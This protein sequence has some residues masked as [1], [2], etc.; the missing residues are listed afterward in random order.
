MEITK[1][2]KQKQ[3]REKL[4]KYIASVPGLEKV[5]DAKMDESQEGMI[6]SVE[7]VMKAKLESARLQGVQIGW[8]TFAKQA[9]KHIKKMETVDEIKVYFQ[10][11]ADKMDE[12]LGIKKD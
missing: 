5:L 11:E 2:Q 9:I 4:E 3:R 10:S 6:M 1:T 12:K 7:D 8:S